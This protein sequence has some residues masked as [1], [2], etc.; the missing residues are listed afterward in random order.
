[1]D[2]QFL[3]ID[4]LSCFITFENANL[5]DMKP[6]DILRAQMLAIV[7]NQIASNDPPAT[8]QT[9]NRLQKEG[10]SESEAKELIAQCVAYEMYGIMNNQEEF[11]QN[12]FIQNLKN[13]PSEP[14]A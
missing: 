11:N 10:W 13:L 7:D 4:S 5:T 3:V 6:N 2:F 8:E 1:M 14:E 12:R 9:L